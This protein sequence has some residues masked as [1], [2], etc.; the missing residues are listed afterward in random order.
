MN[1]GMYAK[2]KM[3]LFFRHAAKKLDKNQP[4]GTYELSV[5]WNRNEWNRF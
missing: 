3:Y 1:T 4:L 2:L 5:L